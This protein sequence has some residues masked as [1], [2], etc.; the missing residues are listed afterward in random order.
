MPLSVDC[1]TGYKACKPVGKAGLWQFFS[2]G[3]TDHACR[4]LYSECEQAC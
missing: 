2:D 1:V 3:G 4:R